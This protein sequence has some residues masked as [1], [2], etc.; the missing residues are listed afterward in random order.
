M[1]HFRIGDRLKVTLAPE[2]VGTVHKVTEDPRNPRW[3][4][5]TLQLDA[6]GIA[7]GVSA[8]FSPAGGGVVR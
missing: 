4:A 2:L 5:V 7:W 6:G 8:W 3:Q 1:P